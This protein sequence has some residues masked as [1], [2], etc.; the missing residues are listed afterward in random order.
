[1]KSSVMNGTMKGLPCSSFLLSEGLFFVQ[2]GLKD[3]FLE[4]HQFG[5]RKYSSLQLVI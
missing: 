1:M 2:Y 4:M 5:D 3:I